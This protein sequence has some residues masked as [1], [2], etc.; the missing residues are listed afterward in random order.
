VRATEADCQAR[1]GATEELLEEGR[2]R[3]SPYVAL[4]VLQGAAV[5]VG[6]VSVDVQTGN[7]THVSIL[8]D[9]LSRIDVSAASPTGGS[10]S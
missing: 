10:V 1:L 7:N 8:S 2:D 5:E 3:A 6:T 9:S 4:L